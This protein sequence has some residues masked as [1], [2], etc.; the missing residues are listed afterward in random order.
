MGDGEVFFGANLRD[1]RWSMSGTWYDNRQCGYS[2]N[3]KH[4]F[5]VRENLKLFAGLDFNFDDIKYNAFLEAERLNKTEISDISRATIGAY[6]GGECE[7]WENFSITSAFRY[8]AA[9][10]S[11]EDTRFDKDTIPEY[12]LRRGK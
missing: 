7:A 5:E 10:T 11:G 12:I 2:L 1:M 4:D 3:A 9:H 6:V 8:E